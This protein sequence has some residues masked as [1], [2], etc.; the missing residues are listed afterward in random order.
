MPHHLT[1]KQLWM[2]CN[3]IKAECNNIRTLATLK[4]FSIRIKTLKMNKKTLDKRE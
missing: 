1:V 2:A 3:I 4:A